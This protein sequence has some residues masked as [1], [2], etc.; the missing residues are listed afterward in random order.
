MSYSTA[1][2]L[3]SLR[4]VTLDDVRGAQKMLWA[5]RG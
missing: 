5:W 4:P 2:S 3:H 1:D